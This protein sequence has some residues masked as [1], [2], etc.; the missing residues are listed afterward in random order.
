MVFVAGDLAAWLI[1]LLADTGRKKLTTLVLG[2][3]QQRALR[4]VVT[5]AVQR[6]AAELRPGDDEQA[7]HLA[8]VVSEVFGVPGGVVAE[9]LT[10]HLL[11]ESSPATHVAGRYFR[12]L[13]S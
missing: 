11:R 9:K 6:T 2:T 1:G 10:V 4:S 7:E 13:P 3:D 8:M 12:W 5:A